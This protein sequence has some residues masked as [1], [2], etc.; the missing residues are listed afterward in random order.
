MASENKKKKAKNSYLYNGGDK[1]DLKM[2]RIMY[3]TKRHRKKLKDITN[4]LYEED[5]RE[6]DE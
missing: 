2:K 6:E 1:N 4:M 5:T 3:F